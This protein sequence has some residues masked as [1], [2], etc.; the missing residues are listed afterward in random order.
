MNSLIIVALL[1]FIS[2]TEVV[3]FNMRSSMSRVLKTARVVNV[4][5]RSYQRYVYYQLLSAMS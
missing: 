4:P 5:S 1:V 2:F 3:S